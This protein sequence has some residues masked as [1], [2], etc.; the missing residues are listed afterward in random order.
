M[1]IL[2]G[3]LVLVL[4]M[5]AIAFGT[6]ALALAAMVVLSAGGFFIGGWLAVAVF[7]DRFAMMPGGVVGVVFVWVVVAAFGARKNKASS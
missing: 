2:T 6:L 4:V 1:V 7:S 5:V 3:I